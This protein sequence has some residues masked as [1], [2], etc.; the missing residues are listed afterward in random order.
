MAA[1]NIYKSMCSSL[2]SRRGHGIPC[3]S[4]A[5]SRKTIGK[6]RDSGKITLDQACLAFAVKPLCLKHMVRLLD[7]VAPGTARKIADMRGWKRNY[8]AG[9]A[10]LDRMRRADLIPKHR[11][12]RPPL[13]RQCLAISRRTYRRCLQWALPGTTVCR[14]HGGRGGANKLTPAE[15]QAK[16]QARLQRWHE[17]EQR[18]KLG[19]LANSIGYKPEPPQQRTL[20]DGFRA[21]RPK[22]LK[23]LY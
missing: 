20:E 6:W 11:F 13:N 19:L 21:N 16:E 15:R 3:G 18:K 2:K 10:I 14:H 9:L 23:P 22:P 8:H 5:I 17:R 12:P 7:D 4:W 1:K